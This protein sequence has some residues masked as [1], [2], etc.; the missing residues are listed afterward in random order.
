MGPFTIML[1]LLTPG[2]SLSRFVFTVSYDF[3]SAQQSDLA[4]IFAH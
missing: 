3:T 2:F 1:R 4:I